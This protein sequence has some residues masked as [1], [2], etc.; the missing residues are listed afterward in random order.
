MTPRGEKKLQTPKGKIQPSFGLYGNS[1]EVPEGVEVG[2]TES[3][4][5]SPQAELDAENSGAEGGSPEVQVPEKRAPKKRLMA[6]KKTRKQRM[7]QTAG[8][9]QPKLPL[10]IKARQAKQASA[11][12]ASPSK[13]V[14]R[15]RSGRARK[16]VKQSAAPPR[17]HRYKPGSEFYDQDID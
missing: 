17:P 6:G 11:H 14:V 1:G 13:K 7:Q 12:N 4:I 15:G 16:T 3:R 5:E 9:K 8:G 10:G 2:E